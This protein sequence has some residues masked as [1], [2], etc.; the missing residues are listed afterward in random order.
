MSA[1]P[2]SAEEQATQVASARVQ[3]KSLI[4]AEKVDALNDEEAFTLWMQLEAESRE[5]ERKH[6]AED[7]GWLKAKMAPTF[8]DKDGDGVYDGF[9][10]AA[11]GVDPEYA[12]R[13][14]TPKTTSVDVYRWTTSDGPN[15]C[16]RF[17]LTRAHDAQ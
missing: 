4:S 16:A 12:M 9:V 5:G 1:S 3:L 6:G 2:L 8:E 15:K 10:P 14:K 11:P 17:S 13:Q 7:A